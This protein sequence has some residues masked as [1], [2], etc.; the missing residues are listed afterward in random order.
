[1]TGRLAERYASGDFGDT[2]KPWLQFNAWKTSLFLLE[3]ARPLAD[4]VYVNQ[5]VW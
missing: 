5:D 2:H 1:M 4:Y 3:S